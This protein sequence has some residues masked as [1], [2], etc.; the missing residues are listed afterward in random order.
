MVGQIVKGMKMRCLDCGKTILLTE[1]TF[2]F[3]CDGEYVKCPHC[4][5]VK[6]VQI[7]HIFGETIRNEQEDK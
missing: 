3:D 2:T 7:Y 6:D 1:D 4:N 5:S